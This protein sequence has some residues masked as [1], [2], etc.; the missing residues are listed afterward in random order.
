MQSPRAASVTETNPTSGLP[1]VP[2]SIKQSAA[3]ALF[4]EGGLATR[5]IGMDAGEAT[6]IASGM[7]DVQGTLTRFATEKD[8]T[9]RVDA[10]DGRR[11]VLKIANP[12]EPIEEIDL[13]LQVLAHIE[14]EH[15]RLPV[16]RVL[17]NKDGATLTTFTDRAGQ[18]RHARLLSFVDGTPLDSVDSTATEREQ[19]GAILARLRL[20]TAEFSHPAD[21][22]SLAWDV[23]HLL[24]LAPLLEGVTDAGQRALLEHGINRYASIQPR[25][26]NLRFQVVHNDFSRS[27]I[28][29]QPGHTDFVTG[30]I[31]FGD[32]VRTAIAIDV[33]TA[34]LNQLPAGD[35]VRMENDIFLNGRDLLRGY[36]RIAD[37]TDEELSLLPH[38]TMGRVI[39]RALLTTWRARIFPDNARYI[40]RNTRQ[41][42]AQL[43]WFLNRS[44]HQLSELLL[45]SGSTSIPSSRSSL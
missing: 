13:Q 25:I 2:D 17:R 37:L 42:W 28:V 35:A 4:E 23:R 33:S 29:V 24:T 14:R 27:N 26:D 12:H 18:V 1:A 41:G 10:R 6:G 20:A 32:I 30:I 15:P 19:V 44:E 34:L 9:F 3:W 40:L 31:D 21:S 38:L 39:T 11:Y 8:D 7:F 16:P 5:Y 43:N 22:R 36:L 45:N